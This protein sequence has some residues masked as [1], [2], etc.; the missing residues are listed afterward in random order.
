MLPSNICSDHHRL[1]GSDWR[2]DILY[3]FLTV[4]ECIMVIW[5]VD[6]PAIGILGEFND[7][8]YTQSI[9]RAN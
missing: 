4:L 8:S 3:C 1:A 9:A 6:Y 2:F 5:G 7:G